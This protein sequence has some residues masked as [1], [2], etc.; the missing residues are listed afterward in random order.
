MVP[1]EEV[2]D[3]GRAISGNVLTLAMPGG[4]ATSTDTDD[5]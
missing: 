1:I 2:P 3:G 5:A 4:E